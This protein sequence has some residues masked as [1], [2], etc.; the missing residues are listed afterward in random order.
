MASAATI[1]GRRKVVAAASASARGDAGTSSPDRVVEMIHQGVLS[2]RYVP[3]Q[4]LIEADLT[5]SLGISRGPVREALKRLSA[6]GIVEIT[7]HRGAYIRIMTRRET[8]D[9]L[10]IL[11]VL[12]MFMARTASAAV[13]NGDNADDVR[14]AYEWLQEFKDGRIQDAALL[15]SR[16]HFYDSLIAIGGNSQLQSVM[17]MMRIHLL[18]LQVQPFFSN[19]D[20][21]ARLEEYAAITAAVLAGDGPKAEQTMKVHIK[22]MRQRISRLP[23]E[24][25]A[26]DD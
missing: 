26:R 4:K 21:N 19:S 9:L 23:S 2:G 3:G 8:E 11:E 6:E 1:T 12:T 18:R 20:R 10:A 22:K 24:A 14:E 5:Q 17:P 25:F 15:D 7:R 16:R 13:R